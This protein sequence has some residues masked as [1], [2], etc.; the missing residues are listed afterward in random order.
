M[1]NRERQKHRQ[2]GKQVL[3]SEADVGLNPQIWDYAR[4]EPKADAQPLCHPG[5][6]LF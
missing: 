6:R 3:H 5:I 2:R 1:R 4:H